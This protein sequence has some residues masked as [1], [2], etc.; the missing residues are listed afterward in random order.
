MAEKKERKAYSNAYH[1]L[2]AVWTVLRRHASREH[3]L[4]VREICKY[5]EQMEQ[6]PSQATV[7]RLLTQGAGLLELFSPDALAQTG[8]PVCTGTYTQEDSL[9]VVLETPE[10]E[11]LRPDAALDVTARPFRAPSYS[12]VDKLLKDE[13][14]FDLNTFPFRLRCVARVKRPTGGYRYISYEKWEERQAR[15]EKS[16]QESAGKRNNAPR[17]YYL[18]NALTQGEWRIFADLVQV[19][20]YISQEQTQKFLTV[21]DRLR[22]RHTRYVP[23]RYAFKRGSAE[24]FHIINLLDQAIREQKKVRVT[25]G[26]YRLVL[27]DRRWQPK[28]TQR[29]KNGVMDVSPYALMWS[30]GNYYLVCCHRGMMN[31]R[32]DRILKAELLPD[33]FTPPPD[34]DPM[35]YRDRCP[36]M[37]PGK[38]EFVRMRC[39]VSLLNTLV[40]FFGPVPQYTKPGEEGVTEV[41]MSIAPEGVR[42]FALQ[43]ADQVEVLEPEWLR[44]KI[45]TILTRNGEKYSRS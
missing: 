12:A 5:L 40:D 9:H 28:L 25:Y 38:P 45:G 26:E 2:E 42:L 34:F 22:P 1:S 20:P 31:L 19:Y 18:A 41:T 27:Q 23:S 10:G 3:P 4:S 44:E 21:L 30:N 6:A 24:Q 13:V 32:A 29:E 17:Y 35:Q 36:V 11:V 37:Y 39:A 15:T 43:Y 16:E 14:P 8:E 7:N 33:S